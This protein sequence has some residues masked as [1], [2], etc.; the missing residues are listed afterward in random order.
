M[1]SQGTVVDRVETTTITFRA[2]WT[3]TVSGTLVAGRPLR[4]VYDPARLPQCRGTVQGNP[5]WAITGYFRLND[6]A[7]QRFSPQLLGGSSP[8]T[9]PVSLP[10]TAGRLEMWFQVTN[11]WGCNAWDSAYGRN[12]GFLVQPDPRAPGWV[13]DGAVVISRG[14]CQGG[15]ACDRDR[16]PLTEGFVYETW[17]RQRAALRVVNFD[18]WKA[19]V[20]DRDNP[21]LW[22]QL[23]VR[24]HYRFGSVGSFQMRYVDFE[25]RVGNNARYGVDLRA[26]DP[27]PDFPAR[28]SCPPVP[29]T[30]S[31]D[32]TMVSTV[33]EYYFTVNGTEY[34]PSPTGFFRGVFSNYKTPLLASC[35][36]R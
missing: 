35:L 4:V 13:G 25:R 9:S 6:G 32:G 23:D 27:L 14:T 19:G 31:P 3:Q 7:V 1:E 16:R 34:R 5:A 36:P 20:T 2:D 24:M 15:V 10:N 18:V 29:L 30:P 8:Q 33:M 28:T 22:R 11:R 17:A 26:L 12:Y 21:D